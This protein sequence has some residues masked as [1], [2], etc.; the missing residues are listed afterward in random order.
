MGKRDTFTMEGNNG[1]AVLLCHSLGNDPSEMRDLA[2]QL[3]KKGFTVHCPLYPGHGGTF[4][5]MVATDVKQWYASLTTAFED[6][7]RT[8]EKV[9]V[10]GMSIG[11]MFAVRLAEEYDVA[12]LMTIN[13][14]VIGFDLYTDLYH[15][16]QDMKDKDKLARYRD[17]RLVYF[18]FVVA[19]GQVEALGRITCPVFVLQ[20][21]LDGARYKTSAMMLM[22]FVQ[23]DVKQR[24]DYAHSR[25]L[26]LLE[27][28]K[29][30]IIQD[31]V[32]FCLEH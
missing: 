4:E 27:Q 22:D 1:Q 20:G 29:K 30:E 26:M 19:T 2:K 24:K 15:Y 6:L 5:D 11:G 3:N 28:D 8:H 9:F 23:S 12:G 31:I 18:R 17:H 13:A 25:H 10:S 32:Q 14:P 7:K 16:A 21:S